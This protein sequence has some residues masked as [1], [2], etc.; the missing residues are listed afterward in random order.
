MSNASMFQM[1]NQGIQ[2]SPLTGRAGTGLLDMASMGLGGAMGTALGRKPTDF[3]SQSARGVYDARQQ[4]TVTRAADEAL[5]SIDYN[6]PESIEQVAQVMMQAG[7]MEEAEKLMARSKAIR[8]KQTSVLEAANV[9]VQEEAARKKEMASKRQAV[10][11]ARKNG[12][13]DVAAAIQAGTITPQAYMTKVMEDKKL[14]ELSK[15]EMLTDKDGNVIRVN[16]ESVNGAGGRYDHS[17]AEFKTWDTLTQE[18]QESDAFALKA[19]TLAGQVA[20]VQDWDSGF[21]ADVEET[22][23]TFLGMRDNPQYLRTQVTSMRN[24]E[25]IGMLPKGP[26]SDR[27]IEIVMQGVPPRNAGKEE[28][29]QFLESSQAVSEKLAMY[30]KMKADYVISGR[31]SQFQDAWERKMERVA[32]TEKIEATPDW[33][34][35]ELQADPS[36]RDQFLD[37]YGWLPEGM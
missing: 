16:P 7:R 33:A 17:V 37:Y 4:E 13:H 5:R 32:R 19:Q 36:L 8:S 34:V 31:A 35:Q 30:N 12:Q 2:A 29:I 9:G 21:T 11:L 3:M 1:I 22:L 15:G 6:N 24:H 10:A 28:V 14:Y 26:A 18:A 27:D 23:L 25:A 20:D